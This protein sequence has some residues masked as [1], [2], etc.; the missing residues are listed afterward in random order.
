MSGWRI[1]LAHKNDAEFL[2]DI[3]RAAA[4]LFAK[5]IEASGFDF[6]QVRTVS[7]YLRLIAQGRT[8]VAESDGKVIGFLAAQPCRRE[9]HIREMDVH[10]DWQGQGIGTILLRACLVDAANAGFQAATLTTF[11]DVP[12]NGPFYKRIGFHEV[13]DI[14]AHPRL[15]EEL[16]AE[17]EAGLPEGRRIAMIYFFG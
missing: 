12:W 4:R 11:R 15:S 17:V 7:H 10:P 16:K 13:E 5:E 14:A 9:L 3:E 6:G 1:R 8:L 2:P